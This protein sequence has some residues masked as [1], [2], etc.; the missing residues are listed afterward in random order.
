MFRDSS[1]LISKSELKTDLPNIYFFSSPN[2]NI[3]LAQSENIE[4]QYQQKGI[5]TE[6][7]T[8]WIMGEKFNEVMP[9]HSGIKALWET[10]W[11]FPVC[12]SPLLGSIFDK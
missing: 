10:K 8:N 12:L 4:E 1:I 3:N 11:K 9:H 6:K 7:K 2:S 5:M